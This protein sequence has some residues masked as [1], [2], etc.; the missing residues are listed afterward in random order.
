MQQHLCR[1]H[2][3]QAPFPALP[4]QP[5]M[6]TPTA[7]EESK[8]CHRNCDKL[9]PEGLLSIT[10]ASPMISSPRPFSCKRSRASRQ[11]RGQRQQQHLRQ[12]SSPI[13]KPTSTSML[14]MYTKGSYYQTTDDWDDLRVH[15]AIFGRPFSKPQPPSLCTVSAKCPHTP[16][17]SRSFLE[18]CPYETTWATGWH[19]QLQVCRPIFANRAGMTKLTSTRRWLC[20]ITSPSALLR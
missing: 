1:N 10:A 18:R 8:V 2:F 15:T 5:P 3:W 17:S 20:N 14:A 11:C 16:P 4:L 13:P 9:V 12:L 7:A 19:M 6:F